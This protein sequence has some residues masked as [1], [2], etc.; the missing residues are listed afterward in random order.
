M[1]ALVCWKFCVLFRRGH[2]VIVP[3][4]YNPEKWFYVDVLGAY[5]RNISEWGLFPL[6]TELSLSTHV[7]QKSVNTWCTCSIFCLFSE[8]MMA[9]CMWDSWSAG[10]RCFAFKYGR[11]WLSEKPWLQGWGFFFLFSVCFFDLDFFHP[12]Y[13]M[14]NNTSIFTTG[15]IM[16]LQE[17]RV[18]VNEHNVE[19]NVFPPSLRIAAVIKFR[20][21]C[22]W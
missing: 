4:I 11:L 8:C 19:G 14:H 7:F 10:W 22:L 17:E 9:N 6:V 13:Y 16:V 5:G 1:K 21:F 18:M 3:P 20:T 12:V 2:M 15:L